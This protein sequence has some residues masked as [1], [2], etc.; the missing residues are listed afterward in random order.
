MKDALTFLYDPPAVPVAGLYVYITTV[1]SQAA[2]FC[3]LSPI[4]LVYL[5]GSI[6]FFHLINRYLILRMSKI[7]DMIDFL[8]FETCVGY[9]LNFPLLYGTGSIIFLFLRDDA[10][11]F[12]YY[13]PSI[14]CIIIWFFSVQSPFGFYRRFVD[15]LMK[16]FYGEEK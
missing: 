1:M 10:P 9:A 13:V 3:H 11:N 6:I 2:F 5:T 14:L 16:C 15:C 4:I 12:G 8:V 7:T